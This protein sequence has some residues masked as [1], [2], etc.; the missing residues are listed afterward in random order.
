MSTGYL[1]FFPQW[2]EWVDTGDRWRRVKRSTTLSRLG[3]ARLERCRIAEQNENLHLLELW[4][5]QNSSQPDRMK[6]IFLVQN[7]AGYQ[8]T[9]S[10]PHAAQFL[11]QHFRDVFHDAT[12]VI[13]FSFGSLFFG[14]PQTLTE[15][16]NVSSKFL[17]KGEIWFIQIQCC[18]KVWQDFFDFF[19]RCLPEDWAIKLF[20]GEVFW[21]F[22]WVDTGKIEQKTVSP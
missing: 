3:L 5:Y 15:H 10:L 8:S 6:S 22:W 12:S 1:P 19:S 17:S 9:V 13:S 20:A 4:R 16:F 21:T 7:P 18:L 2:C 11:N 14:N